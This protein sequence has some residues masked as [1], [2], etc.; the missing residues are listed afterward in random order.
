MKQHIEKEQLGELSDAQKQV[1]KNWWKPSVGDWIFTTAWAD[2]ETKHDVVICMSSPTGMIWS[3][4]LKEAMPLLSIG[5]MIEFLNESGEYSLLKVH[6]EVLGLPH[7]W[8]VGII[9][10]FNLC[11]GWVENEYIIKYQENVE[12]C[13]A[14][15]EAVKKELEK[16]E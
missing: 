3:E 9:E 5:Q 16:N 11:D 7:N 12:L 13:D 10:N 15:W 2:S 14:L 4:L 8:G 6:S 1:L